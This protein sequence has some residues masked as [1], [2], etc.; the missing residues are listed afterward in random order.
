M[1]DDE[2]LALSMFLIHNLII[3]GIFMKQSLSFT[4]LA[5]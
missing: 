2:T 5:R 4:H 1:L 3:T